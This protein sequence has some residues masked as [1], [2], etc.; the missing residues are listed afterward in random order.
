MFNIHLSIYLSIYLSIHFLLN[1][2]L[3]FPRLGVSRLNPETVALAR[4]PMATG[5]HCNAP[6][7]FFVFLVFWFFRDWVSLCTPG[8]PQ[9]QMSACLCLPRAGMKGVGHHRPA[10]VFF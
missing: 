8:W 2:V 7:R 9:T 3:V 4:H 5:C 1:L 6:S 10:E